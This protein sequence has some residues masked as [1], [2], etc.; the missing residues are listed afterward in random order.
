MQG[1]ILPDCVPSPQ[2]SPAG[3][4]GDNK[5]SHPVLRR[6]WVLGEIPFGA[7]QHR[8]GNLFLIAAVRELG[9]FFRVRYEGSLDQDA[10]NIRCFQHR[11]AGLFDVILVQP[12]DVTNFTQ[13]FLSEPHAVFDL[14]R[15]RKIEQHAG[16]LH[17]MPFEVDPADK[18]SVIFFLGQ[19]AGSG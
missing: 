12:V 3:N 13:H 1:R 4:E 5:S 10:G 16:E 9:F 6:R 18:I 8:L 15:G 7:V 2:A 17:T 11:K 19:P 14:C